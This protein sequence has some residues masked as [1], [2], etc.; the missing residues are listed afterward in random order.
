MLSAASSPSAAGD[1]ALLYAVMK[2][3]DPTSSVR[4]GEFATAQNA[5]SVPER[6]RSQYNKLLSGETLTAEQRA[7][8]VSTAGRIY[9][10]QV[11]NYDRLRSRYEALAIRAGVDPADV[12]GETHAIDVP[13]ANGG[14]A[15]QV[16]T[17]DEGFVY[18]GGN[19]NDQ[20]SWVRV[21]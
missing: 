5:G 8:F 6:V 16:G 17:V 3:N 2:M 4:E 11:Q 15:L 9:K 12:I 20:S 13:G 14:S 1:I 19:P 7:D 10:G 21:R 18:I